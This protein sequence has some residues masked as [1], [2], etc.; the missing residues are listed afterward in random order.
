MGYV[1]RYIRQSL[2]PESTILS[3]RLVLSAQGEGSLLLCLGFVSP[4][5][6]I[7]EAGCRLSGLS[8]AKEDGCRPSNG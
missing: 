3:D 6:V 2:S 8:G 5:E 4:R 1:V 7:A